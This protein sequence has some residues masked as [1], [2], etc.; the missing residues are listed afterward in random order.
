M[1]AKAMGPSRSPRSKTAM[2]KELAN[3][4]TLSG[5]IEPTAYV[6]ELFAGDG[7]TTLFTL[8]DAPF[9]V[10]KP[11]L[12]TD[13][14]NQSTFN[15]QTWNV[16]DPGSHLSLGGAGLVLSGGNG[17]DGQTT[18]AA[19]D[20]VEMG[21]SLVIQA[22]NVQLASPSD[23]VLCGLYSGTTQRSN[24]FAGYNVRQSAGS[25]V[26]TPFVNGAEVGTTY[27]LLS[28]HAYTLRIRLHS[29][30]MQR[31]LQ[32]YYTRV[33]GAIQA[34]GGGLVSSPMKL[35]LRPAGPRQR[36]QHARHRPLRRRIRQL[37]RDLHLRCHRLGRTHRLRGLLLRHP[38][39]LRLGRQHAARWRNPDAPHRSRRRRRR[40]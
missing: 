12:L 29:P 35:R 30:E 18:L 10:T 19:I 36:L 33:D 22:G 39:R 17:Y 20:Q 24:C 25:T 4:V 34:F 37:A 15:T 11:T 1:R 13:S 31:V 9:H 3:D 40:L 8:S 38:D 21:G 14:F 26:I 23:G 27:T 28:G 32:T 7:T 16:T 5:A 6:S 2:V